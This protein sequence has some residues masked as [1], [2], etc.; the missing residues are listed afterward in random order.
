MLSLPSTSSQQSP[1]SARQLNQQ[2]AAQS[3]IAGLGR[4]L[5]AVLTETRPGL[6]FLTG[7]DTADAVL[8]FAGAKGIRILG[9]IVT[10]V[11]QGTLIGGP[12][13]GLPVVTKAGAF[14]REDT[15][16][17]LHETWQ[18][19]RQWFRVQT[20]WVERFIRRNYRNNL[21]M[22]RLLKNKVPI[23]LQIWDNSGF[24]QPLNQSAIN[25]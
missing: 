24:D 23:I 2:P 22:L 16:A 1:V 10:G 17:V 19:S 8:T 3:M 9:E 5:A 14:G 6:L 25:Q 13:D 12:L 21:R 7:G 20:F 18:R 4:F 15:L 11:V